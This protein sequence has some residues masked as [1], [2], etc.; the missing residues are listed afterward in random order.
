MGSSRGVTLRQ[1][2]RQRSW[3]HAVLPSKARTV[4]A[5]WQRHHQA[6]TAWKALSSSKAVSPHGRGK[7]GWLAREEARIP[8]VGST[9]KPHPLLPQLQP[10]G[11]AL[12]CL[13]LF[14]GPPQMDWLGE[15]HSLAGGL[16]AWP[17][18]A[19]LSSFAN[20]SLVL[21]L[22]SSSGTGKISG[23]INKWDPTC[24]RGISDHVLISSCTRVFSMP[25]VNI[26]PS[27][28]THPCPRRG[29]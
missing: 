27:L 9:H 14:C 24:Q 23:G 20:A 29:Q 19:A 2:S 7:A 5:D 11:L 26:C 17:F 25:T 1:G 15:I 18:C 28:L 6:Q 16:A 4:L 10:R 12:L 8:D 3:A 21:L 13:L 22:K